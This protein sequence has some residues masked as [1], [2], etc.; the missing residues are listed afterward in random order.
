MTPG[1]RWN[2]EITAFAE[3]QLNK[4]D[5]IAAGR[6]RSYVAERLATA[7][8][9]RSLGLK[10]AGRRDMWRFRVGDYRILASVHNDRMCIL[11]LQVGARGGIYKRG[12]W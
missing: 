1:T 5:R 8:D 10:M 6:I 12:H 9:P 4:L 3:K 7:V 2:V 11:I